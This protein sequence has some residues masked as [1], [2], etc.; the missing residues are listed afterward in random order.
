MD[1]GL[2]NTDDNTKPMAIEEM[3]QVKRDEH[4]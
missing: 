1:S 4:A 2:K 3:D